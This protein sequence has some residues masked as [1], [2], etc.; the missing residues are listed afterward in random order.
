MNNLFLQVNKGLFKKGLTPIEILVYAQVAEFIRT[1][2]E[3]F[4]SDAVMAEN[5]GVSAKTINNAVSS[6]VEKGFLIKETENVKGGRIRH[7]FTTENFSIDNG[8]IFS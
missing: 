7:L 6:L 5:F 2:G 3:C 1:T 8:K 4:I